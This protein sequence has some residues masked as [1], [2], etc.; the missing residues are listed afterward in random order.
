MDKIIQ[1]EQ[2]RYK[3]FIHYEPTGFVHNMRPSSVKALMENIG[4]ENIDHAR[5]LEVGCGQG[6]LVSHFLN[7]H[8]SYVVGTDL[9]TE[10][11][12]S[13]PTPAFDVYRNNRKQ[14]QSVEFRVEDFQ[15]MDYFEDMRIITMF[16]GIYPL[17]NRLLDVFVENP[18]VQIIAFMKPAKQRG[19]MDA[20]INQLCLEHRLSK[21]VFTIHLSGSGEQRQ[22]I[23][24]SRPI[25]K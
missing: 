16:I 21:T 13:I 15:Q 2:R 5:V 1:D 9:S 25:K 19:E 14:R 20:K 8:A 7:L 22:A 3:R 17:V 4:L 24:A 11:I 23:V 12:E 10:I 6:Y 18:G